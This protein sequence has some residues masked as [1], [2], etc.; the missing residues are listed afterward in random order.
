MGIVVLTCL[1]RMQTD[2]IVRCAVCPSKELTH[3]Q[4]RYSHCPRLR[5]PFGQRDGRSEF[6]I[7]G[8]Y[9]TNLT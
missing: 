3:L 9:T 8:E 1:L 5:R 2:S 7:P 6:W 4:D